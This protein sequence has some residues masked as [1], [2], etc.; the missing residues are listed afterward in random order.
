MKLK[1]RCYQREAVDTLWNDI[2]NKDGNPLG[3][4]PTGVGKTFIM[5]AL[6]RKIARKYKRDRVMSLTH[7]AKIIDQNATAMKKMWKLADVGIY[8]SGLNMRDKRN[9]VI[10]AGI[11]SVHR[12]AEEFGKVNVLFI[13]EAHMLSPEQDSMYDRFI[14]CLLEINPKMKIIYLSATPYRLGQG[15]LTEHKWVD[16]VSF[17]YT[18][19]EKFN[20]FV[21]QGYLSPL[22]TKKAATEF[23]VSAMSI[24]GGDFNKKQAEEISNTMENNKAVVEECIRYGMDRKHW[25][26]FASG[27]EHGIALA[28][29]FE[30]YGIRAICL[31]SKS[32]RREEEQAKWERGKYRAMVNVG[33]YT[34]GYDFTPL[35]LIAVARATQSTALWVQ[36]CGRGTRC[37]YKKGIDISDQ[38]GRLKAI[39]KGTKQNCLILD[40][41]GNTRRLGAINCPVIPA[42]R[43]KG[44]GNDGEAPV[45]V[46]PQCETYAHTRASV[47]AHCGYEF[48]P[49]D[50]IEKKAG[51][52]DVMVR[53][54]LEPNTESFDVISTLYRVGV[55]R[56]T[57]QPYFRT[58]Y[59]T[60][61]GSFVK[62]DYPESAYEA[63]VNRF[64]AFWWK[65]LKKKSGRPTAYRRYPK[66]ADE[67]V[68]RAPDELK[69]PT[70][71]LVDM[72]CKFQT[73][74]EIT[75]E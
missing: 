24:K 55:S 8:S 28:E 60:L 29:M 65:A 75:Y 33:L 61:S 18:K 64:R 12:R 26:V 31:H 66:T 1:Q 34:T 3:V 56:Q 52:D 54:T 11:Q 71:I 42:K 38:T 53:E 72:N 73:I 14:S 25:M 51:Q 4:A 13:D 45:K 49:P 67:A 48:P 16:Y 9:R 19:T 68:E 27:I 2:H 63:P 40:F 10:Y 43:Q 6:I 32:E 41:A 58:N 37:V 5:N 21:D 47:C 39:K 50:T 44:D 74:E 62:G 57:K 23:D 22:I 69:E 59:A 30:S 15:Y 35:D 20:W 17:D 70:K 7:D 46:C 36:M